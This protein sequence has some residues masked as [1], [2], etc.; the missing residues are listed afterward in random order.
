[1]NSSNPIS[2]NLLLVTFSTSLT[3]SFISMIGNCMVISANLLLQ[4]KT[5]VC[6][7]KISLAAVNLAFSCTYVAYSV[8]VLSDTTPLEQLKWHRY[9]WYYGFKMWFECVSFC[10]VSLMALQRLYAIKWPYKYI[11][12][13][14]T[15]Q[16]IILLCLVF[17]GVPDFVWNLL[18]YDLNIRIPPTT[19]GPVSIFMVCYSLVI[20]FTNNM[21]CTLSMIFTYLKYARD[22]FSDADDFSTAKSKRDHRRTVRIT[23]LITLGYIITTLPYTATNVIDRITELKST[24]LEWE[25]EPRFAIAYFIT[26]T[27]SLLMTICDTVVYS[28]LDENFIR[29]TK[30]V[31]SWITKGLSCM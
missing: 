5:I 25:T 26:S 15:K 1:M 23:S 17:A 24:S 13:T 3:L 6:C 29:H 27:W 11:C 21:L 7:T 4:T 12:I 28:F 8:D 2:R 9:R 31:A 22:T 14:K 30:S 20:P 18:S 16:V 10:N 19:R